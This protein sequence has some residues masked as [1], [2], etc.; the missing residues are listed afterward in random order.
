MNP[1]QAAANLAQVA[2]N[3]A[4]KLLRQVRQRTRRGTKAAREAGKRA[5]AL[6]RAAVAGGRDAR[7]HAYADAVKTARYWKRVQRQTVPRVRRELSVRHELRAAARGERPIIVGPWLS[8]V[9]Y[10]VLYWVPFLRWFSDRYGV[11]PARM[12][13]V[14]RGGVGGWYRDVAGRYVELLDLYEPG[15]FARR[16]LERQRAGEQKQHGLAAFDQDIL[17]RVR[18]QEGLSDAALCH[19]SLMFR[20]LREFWLGNESLHYVQ[21]HTRFGPIDPSGLGLALPTLPDRF[22]AMKFYTG[23][24]IADTRENRAHLRA[25]VSRVAAQHPIVSLD[26]GLALDEH[27]DYLFRDIPR[28]TNL[29]GSLTPQN[30]LGLQS[31]VIA[32]ADAFIGTCGSL[33]WLAPFLGTDTLAVYADDAFL[34]PHLYAARHAYRASATAGFTTLDLHAA[35]A[36]GL[37]DLR[38]GVPGGGVGRP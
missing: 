32:R 25:L 29:A 27:E 11:D 13:V 7:T 35:D 15:T 2:W 36:L 24:A 19:P 1:L 23:V 33:A 16:N 9:G 10:E 12:V 5:R 20:L 3:H 22:V 6:A 14:S 26:T 30:N 8:E 28:V 18:G 31:A 4:A 38:L 17:T 21:E 34:T 37:D